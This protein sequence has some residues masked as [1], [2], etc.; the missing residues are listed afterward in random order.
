MQHQPVE[1]DIEAAQKASNAYNYFGLYNQRT[2]EPIPLKEIN[3]NAKIHDYIAEITYSQIYFNSGDIRLETEYF[4]P[5]SSTACFH[6]FKAK[7]GD[8]VIEGVIKEKEEAKQKYQAHKEQGDLVAYAEISE[9]SY[10]VMCMKIGNIPPNSEIEIIFSYID[11]LEISLN[12]F[13]RFTVSSCIVPRSLR[14]RTTA[15]GNQVNDNVLDSYPMYAKDV[16]PNESI[17][18][19]WDIRVSVESR[20]PI[21]F[22]RS[23]SHEVEIAQTQMSSIFTADVSFA[24]GKTYGPTKDFVL[25][26][27]TD[28]INKPSYLI[29]PFEDGYCA[30]INFFP[31]IEYLTFDDA[32]IASCE[33]RDVLENMIS[34]SKNEFIF[35]LEKSVHMNSARTKL[36]NQALEAFLKA[37]PSESY[38]SLLTI[39]DNF[40][41]SQTQSARTSEETVQEAL[42]KTQNQ[43]T[44]RGPGNIVDALEYIGR[45]DLIPGH[46]RVVILLTSGDLGVP[47]SQITYIIREK[48]YKTRVFVLGIGERSLTDMVIKT[49]IEGYGSHE[50][51]RNQEEVSEKVTHILKSSVAPYF[52]DFEFKIE[53]ERLFSYVVPLPKSL[54]CITPNE[55]VEFF[56]I[57]NKKLEDV[58]TTTF[59][60]K[61]FNGHNQ[62]VEEF[63]E[64]ISLETADPCEAVV[65]LG[66]LKFCESL[67]KKKEIYEA[68]G[69]EIAKSF[70]KDVEK[71]LLATSLRHGILTSQTAFICVVKEGDDIT[72]QIPAEKITITNQPAETKEGVAIE[73]TAEPTDEDHI[74]SDD[75]REKV[76][77]DVRKPGSV[78]LDEKSPKNPVLLSEGW[79][80]NGEE[81]IDQNHQGSKDS[82]G[83]KQVASDQLTEKVKAPF[84]R[85][86][87]DSAWEKVMT[88]RK[89]KL[90]GKKEETKSSLDSP[91][92]SGTKKPIKRV[93]KG[94]LPDTPA[95]LKKAQSFNTGWTG[96]ALQ[97]RS[98][99][100]LEMK[101]M[102]SNAAPPSESKALE[103]RLSHL[104]NLQQIEGYWEPVKELSKILPIE[105]SDLMFKM[106]E[107]F[108]HLE[109]KQEV[110]MTLLI[111]MWLERFGHD[112]ANFKRCY[113]KAV[114]W[115]KKKEPDYHHFF[116]AAREALMLF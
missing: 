30:L 93:T 31:Q 64:V 60:L 69:G 32:Y 25:L 78:A 102:V 11:R 67:V 116:A 76:K 99:R 58:R 114:D 39:G 111:L 5:I 71:N 40:P 12:K 56:V 42:R 86:E 106:P 92:S 105:V 43:T 79:A 36:A 72:R 90:E 80:N 53:D 70:Q 24:R 3:V 37:L 34:S 85:K 65:K 14:T 83:A 108:N 52:T 18:T 68:M 17:K 66:M 19:K 107:E 16:T 27:A 96:M 62:R 82:G 54:G 15:D 13:W 100:F 59:G 9:K 103:D 98:S 33:G 28:S 81:E 112:L 21:T 41:T 2:K 46:S 6:A 75:K 91:R 26:Y 29:S 44:T 101:G 55:L 51:V 1:T 109:L 94:E 113:D 97:S 110:W 87:I 104:I 38:F 63:K 84:T 88:T 47:V 89:A 74:L 48:L 23:P 49:A 115:L 57:F 50:I 7:F 4:F 77:D 61:F 10:S 95:G 73:D 35:V 22:I 20:H 45:T 8:T